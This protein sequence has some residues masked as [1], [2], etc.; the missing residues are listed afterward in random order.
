MCIYLT[1]KEKLN[2]KNAEH[3][4]SAGLG[5]KL[6]LPLGYV[7]D[8]FNNIISKSEQEFLRSSIISL[9]RQISGPGKRGSLNPKRETKSKI[10]VFSEPTKGECF[11][12]GYIQ[13]NKPFEIPHVIFNQIT[14]EV[15]FN[16]PKQNSEEELKFFLRIYQ[17]LKT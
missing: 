6:K 16:F 4:I 17:K 11:S 8:E 13:M 5:G 3:I 2:Y 1:S 15:I 12:L 7:S 10:S 9:P 14:G